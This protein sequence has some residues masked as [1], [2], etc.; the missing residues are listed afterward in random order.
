MK[1]AVIGGGINGLCTAWLL[2]AKGHAVTVFE[3]DQLMRATSSASTKLLHGGLRY[4]ETANFGLVREALWE[5]DEWLRVAP[6]HAQP[7]PLILPIYR[8]GKRSRLKI[9]FGL[10]LYDWLTR[11]SAL[12]RSCWLRAA[13]LTERAPDLDPEGLRGGYV[14]HDGQMDD[15][16]LG[17]WVADRCR[18][19]GVTIHEH[20]PVESV[21]RGGHV[22]LE[23]GSQE[24]FGCVINVAGPWAQA[25][26][27]HSSIPCRRQLDLV[28][29][30][31]LIVGRPCTEALL[32]EVPVDDRIVF[33]LPW[34]G[35]TLIGTT[36][37]Q[38][39]LSD[40]I[41]CTDDERDYLLNAVNHRLASPIR[42]DEIESTFAGIRPLI[43]SRRSSTN[44]SRESEIQVNGRVIAVFGGKWTTAAALA[45][46]VA[47]HV[48]RMR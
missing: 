34:K 31:H 48:N 38:Q 30:S 16:A 6:E 12:P 3:R 26:L 43:R 25:L 35:R 37:V 21:H 14:F 9:G 1:I 28:R 45:R 18:E 22:V 19:H 46:K 13:A 4:L 23:R 8:N 11:G 42:V 32:L 36:E 27:E 5:R 44:T 41:A 39:Q 15:Y 40:P 10:K 7:L 33:V 2:A 24:T 20:T 29:G 47:T 17:L